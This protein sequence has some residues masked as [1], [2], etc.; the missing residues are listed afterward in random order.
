MPPGLR[1]YV[2]RQTVVEE[3]PHRV[4]QDRGAHLGRVGPQQPDERCLLVRVRVAVQVGEESRRQGRGQRLAE[5]RQQLGA[6]LPG[7]AGESRRLHLHGPAPAHL[8]GGGPLGCGPG[9]EQGPG[10]PVQRGAPCSRRAHLVLQHAPAVLQPV[11][12]V[13]P[14]LAARPTASQTVPQIRHDMGEGQFA[15][16]GD[17]CPVQDRAAAQ[18]TLVGLGAAGED[19]RQVAGERSADPAQHA[20]EP[21]P[22]NLVQPV[23]AGQHM[24]RA[25]QIAGGPR[26][27]HLRVLRRQPPGQPV[28]QLVPAWIVGTQREQDGDGIDGS[29]RAR[30]LLAHA[31]QL[32]QEQ[33]EQRR[34]ARTGGPDDH[35]PLRRERGEGLDESG[36]VRRAAGESASPA[37]RQPGRGGRPLGVQQPGPP[38]VGSEASFVGLRR[39]V[40]PHGGLEPL[41]QLRAPLVGEVTVPAPAQQAPQQKQAP[42][43]ED[44]D[45]QQ[46]HVCRCLPLRPADGLRRRPKDTTGDIQAL[47]ASRASVTNTPTAVV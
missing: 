31:A 17:R 14:L 26:G 7:P 6:R 21:L 30:V 37:V 39:P 10:R 42:D 4:V 13:G 12:E 34:L 41:Q 19:H 38:R 32:Q 23:E 25:Q 46:F 3:D 28:Q 36:H 5:C 16:L 40:A 15:R 45:E 8:D 33:Q 27:T 35:Q 20:H 22:R 47:S 29:R 18:R 43:S 44:Q 11:E 1:P 24:T 9:R 2:G